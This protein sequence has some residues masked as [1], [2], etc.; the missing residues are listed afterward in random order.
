[1]AINVVHNCSPNKYCYSVYVD[2]RY[3]DKTAKWEEITVTD[4][5]ESNIVF[6]KIS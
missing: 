5:F 4:D 6:V 1:M 3:R 2:L